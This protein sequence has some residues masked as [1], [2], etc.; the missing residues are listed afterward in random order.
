[1]HDFGTCFMFLRKIQETKAFFIQIKNFLIVTLKIVNQNVIALMELFCC[2]T[3]RAGAISVECC[4][5]AIIHLEEKIFHKRKT[6]LGS[7]CYCFVK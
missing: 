7:L 4:A 1:M 6:Y 3:S 2:N 5:R